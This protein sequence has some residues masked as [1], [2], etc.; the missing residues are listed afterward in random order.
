[1]QQQ[2][3]WQTLIGPVLEGTSCELVGVVCGGGT[4]HATVRV[5]LDKPEGIPIDELAQLSRKI[6]VVFDVHEPIQGHYTLEVSSP[7][8]DR[9]LFVPRHFQQQIGKVISVKTRMM[10]ENRQNFKGLLLDASETQIQ[11]TLE[12]GE[13][14]MF[15]YEDIDRAKVVYET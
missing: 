14:V 1:M 5:Y 9:P 4:R 8:L 13:Q 3:K 7:G 10:R 12:D 2:D 11:L 15:A 6:S